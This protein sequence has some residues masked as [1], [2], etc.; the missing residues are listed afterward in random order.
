MT[1]KTTMP[2]QQSSETRGGLVTTL[3]VILAA[4]LVAPSAAYAYLDAGSA[5]MLFQ[6]AVA[7][8]AGGTLL[9]KSQWSRIRGSF[10]RPA[11]PSKRAETAA[12]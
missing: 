10:R 4:L 11:V 5:S 9:L 7:G 1:R 3:I 2:Y 8:V 6:A 12:P